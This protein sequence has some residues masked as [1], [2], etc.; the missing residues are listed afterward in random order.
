MTICSFA[1]SAQHLFTKH[2]PCSWRYS[3][4]GASLVAFL[5]LA[6]QWGADVNKLTSDN[7]RSEDHNAGEDGERAWWEVGCWR[8][9]SCLVGVAGIRL[10]EEGSL[11]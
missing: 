10:F 9:F 1:Q 4:N 8:G 3:S 11:D 6:L 7:K 2:L 5:Q